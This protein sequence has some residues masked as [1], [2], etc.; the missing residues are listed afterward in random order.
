[1]HPGRLQPCGLDRS[2]GMLDTLKLAKQLEAAH[3]STEQAE[4]IATA[5]AEVASGELATKA[6]LKDLEMRLSDKINDVRTDLSLRIDHTLKVILGVGGLTWVLQIF[7]TNLKHFF[8][9]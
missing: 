1:M 2:V 9:F 7:G 6:D 4:A 5:I 8:G 3:L